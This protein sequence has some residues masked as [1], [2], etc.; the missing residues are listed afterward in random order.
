MIYPF[1]ASFVI[2]IVWMLYEMKKH[3]R[4]SNKTLDSYWDREARANSVRRKPIDDLA[5]ITIPLETLPFGASEDE[6]VQECESMVRTLSEK[7]IVNLTGMSNTDLKYKYGAPNIT[8]L[9]E[10]DQNYILLVRNLNTWATHLYQAG[11]FSEAR[12]LLEFLVSTN[13]DA[14]T[15][16]KL[17]SNIYV[18][19]KMPDEIGHLIDRVEASEFV[20]KKSIL[21]DLDAKY[22]TD[23]SE[24]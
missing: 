24:S 9:T 1:F 23:H 11:L 15:T 16:Y 13:V 17:L 8:L 19:Q 7:K 21:A 6:K 5:Y 4:K 22:F 2:F 12:T 18:H 14:S 10:Y 3:D 20:L